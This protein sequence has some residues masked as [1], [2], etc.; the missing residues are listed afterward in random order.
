[1]MLKDKNILLGVTGGIAAYKAA[2]LVRL[3][4]RQGAQVRVVM[5]RSAKDFITPVTMATL[6][7]NPILVENFD[8]ENGAW[9]S[10][11]SLGEW[12]DLY[13]I[14]P[15]TANTLAK[16]SAGV[17]DN[18]LLCTYLSARCPVWVA[19]AMD[20][21]MYLH[22]TTQQNIEKLKTLGVKVIEP[23]EGFLASGLVG[24]GRMCE[25]EE[26]A[27]EVECFFEDHTARPYA[28]CRN[29]SDLNDKNDRSDCPD[30]SLNNSNLKGKTVLITAGG[31]IE[32]IDPVR[33]ISNHSTGQMG[34]ALADKLSQRG[35]KVTLISGNATATLQRDDIEK[36]EALSAH[37]MYMAVNERFERTDIAIFCA[38]VADYTPCHRANQ[39][40]KHQESEKLILE[41][42]PTKDIAQ[43]MGKIKRKEQLTIGF[44]LETENG[45]ANAIAKLAKKNLDA[46]ILNS[47]ADKGAGFGT[48]TNKITIIEPDKMT[49]FELKSK[50]EVAQ[51]VVRW[52][53]D[54][55]GK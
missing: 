54:Y 20:F 35:A 10:H 27:R 15:A 43:E 13:L 31:T 46:I 16:M 5:T 51:D 11:I 12:A 30:S 28:Q 48:S 40:I 47:L 38:A 2:M 55:Q 33:F 44:A 7:G 42:C 32:S 6:S 25:P 18:L 34:Y 4:K 23:A 9:N 41:L 1:M 45:Q 29:N 49:E 52:I 17:A 8:P 36:I 26:I 3:F 21:D 39:K 22:S 24:K 37:E 50:Q 14:A 19:P 53:E